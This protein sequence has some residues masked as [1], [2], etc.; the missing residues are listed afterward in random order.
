MAVPL[1]E[2]KAVFLERC[3]TAGLPTPIRDILVGKNLSTLAGLAFAAGQPGE[4]P[5]DAALTGLARAG[6]EEVPIATLASLR[7][8][9]FEAQLLMTAQ[10]KM[11]IEHRADD[12]KAELAPAERSERIQK[13]SERLAGVALR[14]ES[15]CSYGSYDL[16]MKMAELRLEKPR[17]ELDVVNSKI[18]LKDQ[19]VDL[20]CQ[21]H[22]PL[23]LHHALHRRALAMDLVGVASYSVSMEF[24]EYLMSHLTMEPPPGYH[25][26]TLHQVLAADRAAWLRLAEKL[27]K[28]LRAGPDGK[29]PLDVELP[30]LQGDPKV[31]FHLLPLG[32]SAS[33]SGKRPMDGD[34]GQSNDWKIPRTGGR[35]K[36][37]GKTPGKTKAIPKSMPVSLKDKWSRTK[38]G[39]P[40]CWAFNTE[41]G[42]C[43][44]IE[45][46]EVFL[47]RARARVTG[48]S[49][50]SL[51][52]VEVFAGSGRLTCEL[53]RL[54]LNDS[55][56]VDKNVGRCL[57]APVLRLNLCD[58]QARELV[59]QM[60]ENPS[61][62][63]VHVSPPALNQKHRS[64]KHRDGA[65]ASCYS[66]SCSLLYE[67]CGKLFS[68]CWSKGILFSCENPGQS[69]LWR[70]PQW[71]KHTLCLN[72]IDTVFHMCM[73]GS[74]SP[75][76]T[77]I[78]H[79]V[80][81]LTQLGV[82]CCGVSSSHTHESRNVLHDS[83]FPLD[84]SRAWA[85]AIVEQ[86]VA[87]GAL[88]RARSLDESRVP[89]HR[90]AQVAAASQPTRKKVPPLVSEFR[91]VATIDTPKP[92]LDTASKKLEGPIPIPAG[93]KCDTTL[94]VLPAG[95][96]VIR[97]Q[98]LGVSSPA[99]KLDVGPETSNPTS[100]RVASFPE[101]SKPGPD[102]VQ[103]CS[104]ATHPAEVFAASCLKLG[105]IDPGKISEFTQLLESELPARGDG[106]QHEFSF[107]V[108]SFVHGGIYGLRTS[109]VNFPLTTQVLAR[110]MRQ[111][112][113]DA[114]F[115]SLALMRDVQTTLHIDTNNS[116]PYLNTVAKVTNF[117]EGGLWVHNDHGDM[118]CPDANFGQ[119]MGTKVD[120]ENGV[121]RFDSHLKHCTL[122]WVKGPRVVLIGF[123]VKGPELMP[124][125][126]VS[127]L[128]ACEFNMPNEPLVQPLPNEE[129]SSPAGPEDP[130]RLPRLLT[131]DVIEKINM[132][133]GSA[134]ENPNEQPIFGERQ[135]MSRP[136]AT[137]TSSAGTEGEPRAMMNGVPTLGPQ[138]SLN[139]DGETVTANL[140][141]DL[142]GTGTGDVAVPQAEVT[143]Q[144]GSTT[145]SSTA[146]G[147]LLGPEG[148]GDGST[149]DPPP[150]PLQTPKRQGPSFLGGVAKAVQAIPHAVEGLV[151]RHGASN[152][153]TANRAQSEAEGYISAQSGSPDRIQPPPQRGSGPATP[154][155]DEDTLRRLNGMQTAA[156]YLYPPEPPSSGMKPPS[157]TSS[158]IQMEVR[159]QLQEFMAMRD[160]E[161]KALRTQ[162]ELLASENQA[163][164]R[165]RA[166]LSAQ[167]YGR[168]LGFRAEN[169][170]FFPSLG[171]FG[172]GFGSLMS[173]SSSP[174]PPAPPRALDLRPNQ[175]GPSTQT[176]APGLMAHTEVHVPNSAH[177]S[178]LSASGLGASQDV[179]PPP[180]HTSSYERLPTEFQSAAPRV[181][182]F[183]A[184]AAPP[185]S[186]GESVP[187]FA[188]TPD[189]A[190]PMSVVL[191]GM[192]QLQGV[193]ADLA[194]T[195]KSQDKREVIKPG[196]T[197]LPELP[198]SGPEACLA[199]SDW[200][201]SVKPAL[202]D[203]SDTSEELWDLIMQESKDWYSKHLKLDAISRLTDKPIASPAI[204][205]PK[206]S[207][208][209]RRIEGML[210][211]AA[212][213]SVRDELSSARVSGLLP[214]M[215]R[216]YTIYAPGGLSEREIGLRQIQ[217][218][219]QGTT[220]RETVDILRRWRRWCSRMVELGGTLPDSS[221][222]LKALE[223]ITKVTLQSHPDVAFRI[224]L[225]RAA[226]QIDTT[227]DDTKIGQLHAQLLAELET[228]G[229]RT[230]KEDRA[231]D[232]ATT[233]NPKIKGVE[234]TDNSPKNGK[235][236]NPPKSPPN[237][238]NA[239]GAEAGVSSG[240]PCTFY[241][242]PNG[243]KKGADCKFVHNWL[244]IPQ[245]ERAQR[246]RT[247]GGKGHRSQDCKAG[248]K[249]EEKAKVKAPPLG[250]KGPPP[251]PKASDNSTQQ[252][253][254]A[255]SG[256]EMTQQQIKTMLA[257]AAVILQQAAPVSTNAQ[258]PPHPAVPISPSPQPNASVPA[259]PPVTPGTPVSLAAIS[260]QI[261]TLRALA[262]EHEIRMVS[263]N[264]EVN[265]AVS[266]GGASVKALLDSGATHAVIPYQGGMRDLERVSVTLA[267][268][269]REEWFKTNGGTLVVPPTTQET[270]SPQLQTIVPLGALVETLGCTVSWSKRKGLRVVHPT[271]GHLKTGV[272]P[273]TCPFVQEDQALRLIG[274]LE[275]QRVK[276]FEES[277][278]AMEAELHQLSSPQDPTDALRK[279]LET[280]TRSQLMSAVFSQP[281][282]RQVPE[283][284]KVRLCEDIPGLTDQAG[285]SLL[286]RLPLPRAKRRALHGSKSWVVSLCS[287]PPK[288]QDPIK[289][290]CNERNLEYLPVDLLEKGG[291]GWDLTAPK[292]VWSVLLW[293]A[294][295][296]RIVGLLASPPHRTWNAIDS[297]EGKRTKDD[298]W[299]SF[300]AGSAGF[301]ESLM[302][303]QDMFLWSLTSVQRGHPVPFL[304]EL[305]SSGHG[306]SGR[307]LPT[308][309]PESF[310]QTDS[311]TA[312]QQW[313]RMNKLDF[314]QGSLGHTWLNPTTVGTN[315]SLLHLSDLP[316]QGRPLPPG[317]ARG[318]NNAGWSV[319]FRKE[320]VEAL[321]GKVKGP[322]VE[323]L[324]RVISKGIAL[325][326]SSSS[327]DSVS[328]SESTDSP[329]APSRPCGQLTLMAEPDDIC[330]GALTAAQK[331]EWRAHILRGHM[332]YRKDCRFCVEGSG[333][334]MQHR[335]VKNPQAFSLSV[336]LFGPM[337]G[338][339]KGRDEQSVSANP[340][341]R[342]G[343]V[344]VFRFPK[345]TLDKRV[346]PPKPREAPAQPEP[347]ASLPLPE[348]AMCDEY[349]PSLPG[350]LG[351]DPALEPGLDLE[352]V[353]ELGITED[354]HK[355]D[356]VE[357]V[358]ENASSPSG[359][360]EVP[361][362]GDQEE[363][364]LGD[365]EL[366]DHLRDL[367]SGVE[368][369]SLRYMIGLKS[370]TGPDVTAGLQKMILAITKTFPLRIVH[371]DPG[372]EFGSDK[373]STWLSQ[374]GIRMQT[375]VPTDKQSNGLAERTVG[376]MKARAR[377]L[378]SSTGLSPEYWP[379]AMRWASESYNRG[380]LGL[381]PLPAFGQPVL[382][383]LKK[384][385]EAS[386]ELMVRWIKSTYAA[387]HLT[388]SEGHVL[389]NSDGNLVAS[390]GF[391]TNLVE[392]TVDEGIELP[393]LHAEDDISEPSEEPSEQRIPAASSEVPEEPLPAPSKR[394]REKTAVRFLD[395]DQDLGNL[396]LMS[397]AALL[398]EDVTDATFHRLMQE[399]ERTE[400]STGDR[401][402]EFQGRYVLGAFCHGGQRGVTVLA[403]KHP[404]FVRFLNKYMKSRLPKGGSEG[405]YPRA[406]FLLIQGTNVDV[407]RDYRNE[408]GT[409]NLILQVPPQLELWVNEDPHK[410]GQDFIPRP[411]WE[412]S[413]SQT[414]QREVISFDPRRYHALRRAPHWVLV[415]YSPLGVHKLR[416]E[417]KEALDALGFEL[418]V[419]AP[420]EIEVKA[421]RASSSAATANS[422]TPASSSHQPPLRGP[423][424]NRSSSSYEPA[425][426]CYSP[427][428][429]L[430]DDSYTPFIGWDPN[431]GDGAIEAPRNL[432][433]ADLREFLQER[434]VSNRQAQLEFMGVESPADLYYL[435]VEDLV[436]M[437]ISLEDSYR[438]MRGVHPEGTVR[439][440]NPNMI[441][442]TTG[443]VCLFGRDH[444]QLPRVIQ[445]RTLTYQAPGPPVQG[446]GINLSALNQRPDPYLEDWQEL[447]GHQPQ[448]MP[449]PAQQHPAVDLSEPAGSSTEIPLIST[450][451]MD[452]GHQQGDDVEHLSERVYQVGV[453]SLSEQ[454]G[455]ADIH[456]M[457]AMRMQAIWD[458]ETEEEFNSLVY[459]P[460]TPITHDE[461]PV[462][463]E[464][465]TPRQ[466][467]AQSAGQPCCRMV[468]ANEERPSSSNRRMP[469]RSPR[470]SA[471]DRE[472]ID[473]TAAV[474]QIGLPLPAIVS[475]D[476]SKV[477]PQ[478]VETSNP[479]VEKVEE[480]SYT[481][482]IEELL[483]NL[484]GP[485]EVVHQVAPADVKAFPD[486][487]KAA[488][489]EEVNS[490]VGMNAIVRHSGRAAQDL[491]KRPNVEVLPAKGVFTVK[492]G[493]PF[494]RKVRIV[495]CGNYA[496]GVSEDILYATGAA[497]ETL[498][499]IL[500]YAGKRR[501]RCWSTDIKCAF[502]LAPIPGSVMKVYVLKPPAILVALGI[503]DPSEYWQVCRAVYGF[504]ESP[505]WWSQYRDGVLAAAVI[506][507]P[508][509]DAT[510][511]RTACDENLWE[512]LLQDGTCLGHM[513]VYVDDL[514]FLCDAHVAESIHSWIRSQWSC[515][516]LERPTSSKA[517]RFLGVDIYET[518]N[519]CGFCGYS[520]S[521]ESYIDE[522]ARSH[523]LKPTQRANTP[524]PKEWVKNAPD[525]ES[526]FSE[527]VLREAQRITG[528]LLWVSQRTRVDICYAVG[529]M[530]SWTVKSPGFVVKLGQRVLAYLAATKVYRLSLTPD[531]TDTLSIYTDASFAPFSER[532]ISGIAVLVN[533]RCVYWK[534][535]RQT[536]VSLST[537][538]CELIAA[539]EGV[540]LG[541]SIEALI[542]ELWRSKVAKVLK[543][544][545]VAA[546]TLAE[547]GGSQ[548]TRHLRV[549]ACFLKEMLEKNSLKVEHCP[550]EI[551]L[552]DTL[553]KA[554]PAPRV[555]DLNQFLGIGPPPAVDPIIQAV[556]PT[557][558]AFQNLDPT[559]G[560][561]IMLVLAIMMLQVTP[562][563]S[564]EEEEGENL[565]LDLYVLA[566]M[567]AFSVLF[568]WEL[569]K[570]CIRECQRSRDSDPVVAVVN[571]DEAM[572]RREKRSEAVR[573]AVEKELENELRQ[574]KG[575]RQEEPPPPPPSP[576]SAQSLHLRAHRQFNFSPVIDRGFA[577]VSQ[578]DLA[579]EFRH[580][581][582]FLPLRLK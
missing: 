91:C 69:E 96:R 563:A 350:E 305:P 473:R 27:P 549:R 301:K 117:E 47:N 103:V 530:S 70:T 546:I 229:H 254:V 470:R 193:V 218:P 345:S 242:G 177:L 460:L 517:L 40:I 62:A 551:Q 152:P 295:T 391:R 181:L 59:V 406:T 33:S 259:N 102:R 154:L 375:T 276:D 266:T 377:T 90:E 451:Q 281:Y 135:V 522:L 180:Q 443:E 401:R 464:A 79:S 158:D 7:R 123:V 496:K 285:W 204:M 128:A 475:L 320:I 367:T 68:V 200:L 553:T 513:L 413:Q 8:L 213:P 409:Q 571:H 374:Q 41:E 395:T 490:M 238:K 39:V 147:F 46:L 274:E 428:N 465:S 230:S 299:G 219:S 190:D 432:E 380:V 351:E 175:P 74:L 129:H 183:E 235:A 516:D 341:L 162:L 99:L 160:E 399:L 9:V 63:Y 22:T 173:G 564:Q 471:P 228:L 342:Y 206:W 458:A 557:S 383:K 450:V 131:L 387:P 343:L 550:G 485:L 83:T 155:L 279:Y 572:A 376:W 149:A 418:P 112:C 452:P 533:G 116:L 5:S 185:T 335:R 397:K 236:K 415:G 179:P 294:A 479:R 226:L 349:E 4:T 355:V 150:P 293:A 308:I 255:G 188:G 3:E 433:E 196:I 104:E 420:E 364:W 462:L 44:L 403:R 337:S 429:D 303:I 360:N 191:T 109:S 241:T 125:D 476:T 579:L 317:T 49:V 371:C 547:G 36:G 339:E 365:V 76:F 500:V 504:K 148:N 492:P 354:V 437:G 448:V 271:M 292:G 314:C 67:F 51:F 34:Q 1:T 244:S 388:I 482:H 250:P 225:T 326:S 296:G 6:T 153:A 13:Q 502:L 122:P 407:H 527:V 466:S 186:A 509:G 136:N 115:T 243:C 431:E 85:N 348:D 201:H 389:I 286:K 416:P 313:S 210:L 261:D 567:M 461:A 307:E 88:P 540:V 28:G 81:S 336:D 566:V 273:N 80:P 539:C 484:T 495:S 192:A 330:V 23:C 214:V 284:L 124:S 114:V 265:K 396:E 157:T 535:K 221:L 340:H 110:F 212:P 184:A 382:H 499:V 325:E 344:G 208:V 73:W 548:R 493:R 61:C 455:D 95:S 280:G 97:R 531:D 338:A 327:E 220:I 65:D 561:S 211:T 454:A 199:F 425:H 481:P 414:L 144:V 217:E 260:A 42:C 312:F 518:H 239:G 581:L 138:Q 100:S 132:A 272:S 402:G 316:K 456:S 32:P 552:A 576:P 536:L 469:A 558:S 127:N 310:W 446:L 358:P 89:L 405:S 75:R 287:G 165:D 215:C 404:S 322:S 64:L 94:T 66:A 113:P 582:L 275:T 159:R 459:P 194:G 19:A 187:R 449:M 145:A 262:R 167:V 510:L 258:S 120:F 11:L 439:P 58:E 412:S 526:G 537:A 176:Q 283:A 257:D 394:C 197:S 166:E 203:V 474:P 246:C 134:G 290:W 435:Y 457:H 329:I 497:A 393:A 45:S 525:P 119:L 442:L 444:R 133:S 311:W 111:Q 245:S 98:L 441:S 106:G 253:T 542:H 426:A 434:E 156:P 386:K 398:D 508:Q 209:S 423:T 264:E 408:W 189:A 43:D 529:L 353:E 379:L 82:R 486:R 233:P 554:L 575:E 169:Q 368:L 556:I 269:Q 424:A 198:P 234:P 263:A 31:A 570:H 140:S 24:H 447:N 334:G 541:Q 417:D 574:R 84:L 494:R 174:K 20:Q 370:K 436:E 35:G 489:E 223:R 298:P 478:V 532:S 72:S 57:I 270:P 390:K 445:N 151:K 319:G 477:I 17:K 161:C 252:A 248:I 400:S 324:D 216:L 118:P 373:L 430:Q 86:L 569:G 361:L 318:P 126:L 291:K 514:L 182:D 288:P 268:D 524:I 363:E 491:L 411:D 267:G 105:Y 227:P 366:E 315:L 440:D 507:T 565:S 369:L 224:N 71:C 37:K 142:D 29:L 108:G 523:N 480:T 506:Q 573:K 331:E 560:Q 359:S 207:R 543:V 249:A 555:L 501:R 56:G 93:A 146:R 421:L 25:Q 256:K 468:I 222:Q 372:T 278:Q 130:C 168:E 60:L 101:V 78:V 519:E 472:E 422:S 304:K 21:L 384:P 247:C 498:R 18:T 467:T 139:M 488:A 202:A 231:K 141:S 321:E 164:Q 10:V 538:E 323:E 521:Q 544:D 438:I 30:K 512:V 2:S 121:I 515:S 568:V 48:V 357:L 195:P 38:R 483:S 505:K 50:E 378:L 87:L 306:L 16:V 463:G 53:R 232:S 289:E 562:V 55:I 54:G 578:V 453:Q 580:H 277:V 171:W 240:T 300:D 12:Q 77:R 520:L 559:E 26:V 528:E 170:R 282:L 352:E 347:S 251:P 297:A 427:E 52:G 107:T 487:W 385:S 14:N 346:E 92:F 309:T 237:P 545:N 392:P 163:L 333:L 503:C 362:Q 172:R 381:P 356:A 15:E 534:S 577:E 302:A 410:P 178:S 143:T 328:S 137:A 332:P 205:Q 419:L 511:K